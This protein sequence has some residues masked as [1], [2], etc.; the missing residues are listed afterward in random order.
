MKGRTIGFFT[1]KISRLSIKVLAGSGLKYV[2]ILKSSSEEGTEWRVNIAIT[3]HKQNF[4]QILTRYSTKFT[5]RP[6]G[7]IYYHSSNVTKV[8]RVYATL[9]AVGLLLIPVVLIF[10]VSLTKIQLLVMMLISVLLF[11]CALSA[12]TRLKFIEV[13]IGIAA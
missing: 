9:T 2:P 3:D 11:T 13:L 8:L 10:T 6:S 1:L 12:S 5:R 7:T 4:W